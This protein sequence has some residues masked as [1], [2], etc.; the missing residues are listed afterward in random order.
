[1]NNYNKLLLD[2][3]SRFLNEYADYVKS[4]Q[5]DELIKF[6]VTK[7]YAFALVLTNAFGIDIDTFEGNEFLHNYL[8]PSL[9]ELDPVIYK[10]DPYYKN[11]HI[12]PIKHGNW[13]IKYAK[14]NPYEAFVYQD[15]VEIDKKIIPQVGFFSEQFW[16]LAVYQNNRLWMSITPNEI[17]T[18]KEPIKRAKGNCYVMGLGLGYF[19]YMISQ[20][21]DVESITIIEKDPEVINLFNTFILPN[22]EKRS[23]IRIINMDAAIVLENIPSDVNYVFVDLWHDVSDGLPWYKKL[24]KYRKKYYNKTIDIWIEDTMKYY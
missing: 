15:M 3:H 21:E 1:M 10:D 14:Y 12:M 13:E 6:G 17:E 22:F 9:K 2:L 5:I 24:L 4:Y 20:K 7:E 18:M 11:I 8:L 19:A 16:Y 23:K